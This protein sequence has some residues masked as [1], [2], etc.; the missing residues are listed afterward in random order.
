MT[1]MGGFFTWLILG[2]ALYLLLL[3]R[4]AMRGCCGGHKH[5]PQDYSHD[6]RSHEAR[7]TASK[8]DIIDLKKEDYHVTDR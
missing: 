8:E 7:S 2:A 3:K 5:S 1:M 6:P 4:G